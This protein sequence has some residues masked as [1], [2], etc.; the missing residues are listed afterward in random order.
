M[1]AQHVVSNNDR[2]RNSVANYFWEQAAQKNREASHPSLARADPV[3]LLQTK[4]NQRKAIN[5]NTAGLNKFWVKRKIR[6]I[7]TEH[8]MI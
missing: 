6:K 7:A 3:T 1:V 8:C 5:A 4:K 2:K